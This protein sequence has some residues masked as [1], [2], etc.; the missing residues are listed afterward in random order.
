MGLL[1][2][3]GPVNLKLFPLTKDVQHL[4]YLLTKSLEPFGHFGWTKEDQSS[5]LTF[6]KL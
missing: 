3:F 4:T 5:D 1:L 2:Y 6:V